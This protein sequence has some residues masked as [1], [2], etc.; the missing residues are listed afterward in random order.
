MRFPN[1]FLIKLLYIPFILF[2]LFSFLSRVIN[3]AYG[4]YVIRKAIW[5]QFVKIVWH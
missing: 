3:H 4:A 1:G 2:A 5:N